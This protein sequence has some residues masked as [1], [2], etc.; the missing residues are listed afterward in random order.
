MWKWRKTA[1]ITF[2]FV[3]L[4]FAVF[5][6]G[7]KYKLSLYRTPH[8][9]SHTIPEAKLLSNQERVGYTLP[10]PV[11]EAVAPGTAVPPWSVPLIL[12]FSSLLSLAPRPSGLWER[13]CSC[14]AGPPMPGMRS[15]TLTSHFFR[16]PP[17]V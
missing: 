16:P 14:F 10:A 2:F 13:I 6:W 8:S 1:W 5:A 3:T 12:V 4:I 9:I 15:A 7:L 17:F 11:S